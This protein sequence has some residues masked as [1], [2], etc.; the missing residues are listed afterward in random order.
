MFSELV[1]I[2]FS[3]LIS[4]IIG[5]RLREQQIQG[6]EISFL[7]SIRAPAERAA[8]AAEK[9]FLRMIAGTSGGSPSLTDA[10]SIGSGKVFAFRAV[11]DMQMAGLRSQ[12][13]LS[14]DSYSD[15]LSRSASRQ[16]AATAHSSGGSC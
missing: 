7:T 16:P 1:C 2:D 11:E 13:V 12:P 4:S 8:D 14:T 15:R 6:T 10:A 9:T 3:N 5:D